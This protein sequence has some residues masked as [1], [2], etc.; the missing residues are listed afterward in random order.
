[1]QS[2]HAARNR[3]TRKNELLGA[4][5]STIEQE[6]SPFEIRIE[7]KRN[8]DGVVTKY[9]A[10]LVVC[11]NKDTDNDYDNFALVIDFTLIK[12]FLAISVQ[13][14]WRIRQVYFDNAFIDGKLEREVFVEL[15]RYAYLD[16]EREKEVFRLRKSLYGLR[17]ACKVWYELWYA[18][19]KRFV[20]NEMVYAPRVFVKPDLMVMI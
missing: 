18:G 13:R 12:L 17:E 16:E 6:R 3:F 14:K 8:G 7:E 2:C 20:L 4:R 9:K 15:P 5:E 1:M 19:L 10:R 11:G